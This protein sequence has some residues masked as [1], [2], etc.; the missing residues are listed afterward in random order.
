MQTIHI[1]M[2]GGIIQGILNIP[3]GVEIVVR[4]YDVDGVEYS[5]TCGNVDGDRCTE[6]HWDDHEASEVAPFVE[7]TNEQWES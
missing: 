3:E 4:D 5:E 2:E 1:I 6:N 7:M